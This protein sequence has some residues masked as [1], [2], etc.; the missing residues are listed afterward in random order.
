MKSAAWWAENWGNHELV[1]AEGKACFEANIADQRSISSREVLKAIKRIHAEG[2]RRL[3]VDEMIEFIG[4]AINL[5][6]P[7]P[8]VLHI[9]RR[10]RP[11]R[12]TPYDFAYERRRGLYQ[13]FV[14]LPAGVRRDT[15]DHVVGLIQ[16]L[17]DRVE[18]DGIPERKR[19]A[20]VSEL[21]TIMGIQP[22]D[23]SYLYKIKKRL[24]KTG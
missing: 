2:G 22:P 9:G 8:Y 19:V 12:K 5:G 6:R 4:K 13:R 21:L 16:R 10:G 3:S 11:T 7:K 14:R 24:I 23:V 15:G 18:K 20:R 17:F 1:K